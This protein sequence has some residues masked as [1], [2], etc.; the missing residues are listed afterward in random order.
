VLSPF[1]SHARRA[2]VIREID[3]RPSLDSSYRMAFERAGFVATSD[4]FLYRARL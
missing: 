1:G 3:G 2:L 4:G